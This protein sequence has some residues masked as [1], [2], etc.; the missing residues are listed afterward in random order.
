[1]PNILD[2]IIQDKK[3]FLNLPLRN[4]DKILEKYET[5]T[6]YYQKRLSW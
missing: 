1:M 6:N 4:Y 2:Q 5:K 3:D